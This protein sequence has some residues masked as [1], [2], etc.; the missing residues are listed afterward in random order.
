MKKVGAE[1]TFFIEVF[2][3][4]YVMAN[5]NLVIGFQKHVMSI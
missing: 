1:P 4:K 2:K 5:V 3:R